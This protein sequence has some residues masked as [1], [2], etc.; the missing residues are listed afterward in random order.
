MLMYNNA[1]DASFKSRGSAQDGARRLCVWCPRAATKSRSPAA[2]CAEA[3]SIK[4]G[5]VHLSLA[6]RS[7][8]SALR[9]LPMIIGS[10]NNFYLEAEKSVLFVE[11]YLIW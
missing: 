4:D 7:Q 9:F 5:S 2:R 3:M 8:L 6:V 11:P 10:T 1:N